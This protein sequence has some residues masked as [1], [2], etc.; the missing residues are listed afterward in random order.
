MMKVDIYIVDGEEKNI[1]TYIMVA[2]VIVMHAHWPERFGAT[3]FQCYP[4]AINFPAHINFIH[5]R[6]TYI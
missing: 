5:M 2:M 3:L 6:P 4:S 1:C